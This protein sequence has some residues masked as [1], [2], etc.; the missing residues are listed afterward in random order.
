LPLSRN[1]IV[2]L[3]YGLADIVA[4]R[5]DAG[6]RSSELVAKDMIAVRI[7]PDI[8][9][10]VV[11]APSYFATRSPPRTPQD[12][13]TH[14]CINLRLRTYGGLYAWEFEKNGRELRVRVEGQRVFNSSALVLQAAWLASA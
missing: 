11:G 14:S 13:T 5:D 7:G 10:A 2:G 3:H 12:L 4:E 8:R 6:L 9:M 1:Q